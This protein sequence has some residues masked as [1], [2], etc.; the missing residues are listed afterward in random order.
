MKEW[1]SK[2]FEAAVVLVVIAVAGRV[3]WAILEPLVPVLSV[4]VGLVVV[5]GVIFRRRE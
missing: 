2:A 3:A 5:Y 1:K 4:L